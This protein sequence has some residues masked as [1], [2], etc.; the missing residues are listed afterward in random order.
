MRRAKI[1]EKVLPSLINTAVV[2]IICL[3]FLKF[4]PITQWKISVVIVFFV[5][6]FFFLIFN[7]NRCL[8][9]IICRTYWDK[10]V[11]FLKELIYIF[12]YSLSFS[13]LFIWLWFPFDIFLLNI[14]FIQLPMVLLTGTTFHGY[15]S[16]N[17]QSVISFKS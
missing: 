12:L 7:K 2:F 8:G 9:M 11:N 4:L 15:M 3:P 14:F 13:T 10:K 5:Y 6:N 16:G 17:K 1:I